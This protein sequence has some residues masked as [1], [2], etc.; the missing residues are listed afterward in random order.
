M[1]PPPTAYELQRQRRLRII[2]YGAH[3]TATAL[4]RVRQ[5]RWWWRW[6]RLRRREALA[7]SS[8]PQEQL[9]SLSRTALK[10]TVCAVPKS[11]SAQMCDPREDD[12]HAPHHL[13]HIHLQQHHFGSLQQQQQ[14]QQQSSAGVLLDL[15][16]PGEALL[17]RPSMDYNEYTYCYG[18]GR[19]SAKYSFRSGLDRSPVVL[20]PISPTSPRARLSPSR[21][22]SSSSIKLCSATLPN[23][24]DVVLAVS[25]CL[26]DGGGAP[27]GPPDVPP[28]NPTMSRLNGRLPGSN[29]TLT[30]GVTQQQHR[31]HTSSAA[32]NVS[33]LDRDPELEPSCLVRTE[34]GNFY[35][36]SSEYTR[37]I[38]L[39]FFA[40]ADNDT[41]Q[42]KVEAIAAVVASWIES[43]VLRMIRA[44]H[45]RDNRFSAL[46]ELLHRDDSVQGGRV[47]SLNDSIGIYI[48]ARTALTHDAREH[49]RHTDRTRA[50]DVRMCAQCIRRERDPS[51]P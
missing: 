11:Q 47:V 17:K 28:R 27:R 1:V 25:G 9:V 22:T 30:S 26:L 34:S 19:D 39:A 43:L 5:R 48:K 51:E 31:H 41:L 12:L 49:N 2:V 13:H 38:R 23:V 32:N 50:R 14:Q 42:E 4:D 18:A 3:R 29:N 46:A 20:V 45:K 10:R 44:A 8:L 24:H 35:N 40:R 37:Y 15:V 33:D 7:L 16:P 21:I 36:I 6:R